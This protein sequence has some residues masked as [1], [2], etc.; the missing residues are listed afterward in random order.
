MSNY[1][2][3]YRDGTVNT[4]NGSKIVTGTGT[5]W[6]SAG[7]QAG[8]IVK[9]SGNDYELASVQSDTKL[10]LT[11]NFTGNALTNAEYAIVR[12]FTSSQSS[13]IVANTSK[14]LGDFARYLDSD[15]T[16]LTGKSAYQS[17]VDNGYT[18]S[19]AKWVQDIQ[20]G[21]GYSDLKTLTS[22]L[23]AYSG[24][25]HNAFFKGK[26]LGS[27]LS[28]EVANEI[29]SGQ[30]HDIYP[31]HYFSFADVPYSYTDANGKTQSDTYTGQ[32]RIADLDYFYYTGATMISTH[33]AVVVPD[34]GM[35]DA[36]MNDTDTTEGG[37]AGSK[38]RTTQ[39]QMQF[40]KRVS[41]RI[42]YS[43]TQN[44]L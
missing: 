23:N 4:T 8:D 26:N 38:M 13:Q 6:T 31:G 7:L 21:G 2:R 3:W 42:M 44:I 37:Y 11:T 1:T 14:L 17:A 24:A 35:F 22:V 28:S 12:N 36:S 15:L 32:I 39:E 5:Y 20:T 43:L 29:S 33:H 19:E 41:E 18:G 30:F 34:T 25:S 16:K 9:L 10:T 40:S 27:A